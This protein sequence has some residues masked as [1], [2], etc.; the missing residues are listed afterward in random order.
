MPSLKQKFAK[1]VERWS[2]V[3]LLAVGAVSSPQWCHAQ[4]LAYATA[5]PDI[6]MWFYPVSTANGSGSV[7]DRGSSFATYSYLDDDGIIQFYGGDGYD[8]SRRGSVLLA[9]NTTSTIPKLDPSR[10]QID[11]LRLTVTLM[12][13]IGEIAYDGTA[14]DYFQITGGADDPGKPIELWGAGFGGDY[15]TFGFAGETGAEYFNS[16]DRRWPISAGSFSGPY[17]VYSVD[18]AGNDVENAIFGGYSATAPGNVT[19]QF[20]PTPFAI[21]RAYDSQGIELAPG[22]MLGAGTELTFDVNLDDPGVVSYLQSSLAAGHLGFFLSSLHEPLA[23]TGEVAYPDYF[24]DNNPSG[25]NPAGAAPTFALAVTILDE[26]PSADFNGDG[27]VD[28]GDFLAW[29]RGYGSEYD[30]AD[31]AAWKSAFAAASNSLGGVAGIPE[32]RAA[33]L[34]AIGTLCWTVLRRRSLSAV[35]G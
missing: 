24:L 22:T 4:S 25:P 23:H 14:D 28:G 12:G 21:G 27:A 7:R 3:G 9:T 6:E 30:E 17:Q 15:T 16:G 29:Q 34:A 10:Y 33:A 26:A 11:S 32:P 2:A 13:N 1:F 20:S 18:G 5:D 8:S 19:E 35:H 31:L